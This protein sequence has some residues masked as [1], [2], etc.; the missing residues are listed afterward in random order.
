MGRIVWGLWTLPRWVEHPQFDRGEAASTEWLG[1]GSCSSKVMDKTKVGEVPVMRLVGSFTYRVE[2]DHGIDCSSGLA[3]RL[4]TLVLSVFVCLN[5]VFGTP[6]WNGEWR[7][8]S[9]FL[10]LLG[11][12]LQFFSSRS[13]AE[14]SQSQREFSVLP[15]PERSFL[16]HQSKGKVQPIGPES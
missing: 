12:D 13:T 16:W 4:R 9:I 10:F 6:W 1:F 3:H 7:R 11:M 8:E 5:W 2:A 15:L 14:I